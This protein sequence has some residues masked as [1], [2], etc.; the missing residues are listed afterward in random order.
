MTQ[1]EHRN[2]VARTASKPQVDLAYPSLT[3]EALGQLKLAW[4]LAHERDDWTKGGRISDG[5][6]R[7]SG[8]P[9]MA[10][11]TYDLT[12]AVRMLAKMAQATPAWREVY[13]DAGDRFASRMTQFA[14]WYDWVEQKGLDPNR[15][16]YP[17]LYYRHTMPPGMAG[18]YNAP[19]YAGN[20]L[21]TYMPGLLQSLVIAPADPNPVHPYFYPHSPAASGRVY[22]PDPVYANGSS[23]MMYRGYFLEQLAHLRR[24]SGDLKYDAPLDL[25]YDDK[26]RYQY[27]AEQIAAGLAE[28]LRAPMDA[29][30]SSLRFGI[31][32]EVGKVFPACV[33]VGGLGM[34]LYD[35]VHGTDFVGAYEEWLDFAKD[36]FIAGD[37]DEDGYFRWQTI[38]Y[39]R[40]I[41]YPM[42]RPETQFPLF[43]AIVAHQVSVFDR[44]WAE[45]V[46]EGVLRYHGRQE[47]DG[48][49]RI[50][51][52]KE[53]V[54][55]ADIH[56]LWA[57]VACLA[58]AHEFGDDE[59]VGQFMSWMDQRYQPTYENGEFYWWFGV[60]EAW[61][62]G[63]P[64]H[65]AA[66]S[67]I[68]GPG[69]FARMYRDGDM[70][71]FDEPT[72]TGIDYPAVTVRQAYWDRDRSILSVGTCR[73]SDDIPAGSPTAFQISQLSSLDCE[74]TCDGEA[75]ADWSP[76]SSGEITIRTTVDDHLFLVRCR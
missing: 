5:F 44:P 12:Y 19:G 47:A 59:R 13:V 1:T 52:P 54:G 37:P 74:I 38:Y 10:K 66:L 49:L 17:Y 65:W 57:T 46:Y 7:W 16:S 62:R 14:G 42:N 40:D 11:F 75:F 8:Y 18:V 70:R 30:G 58:C 27:S 43:A 2:V 26:I 50:V 69:D 56:D 76:G 73:G 32:C 45:R 4:R 48:S 41:N 20:G 51:L 64:N 33:S 3:E 72:V 67:L 60:D 22:D 6:D 28:Q 55:P 24:I 23:N 71:R 63:I 61:P 31:D 21:Q 39:D 29:N 34:L 9:Y 25:V 15:A 53:I 35:Q 36:A 68:G